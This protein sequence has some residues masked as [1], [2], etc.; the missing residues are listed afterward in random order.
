M[1]LL[2]NKDATLPFS[3]DELIRLAVIGPNANAPATMQVSS[4]CRSLFIF[5]DKF[6][7]HPFASLAGKLPR[8]SSVPHFA[9]RRLALVERVLG[10]CVC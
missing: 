3:S 9:A 2:K 4:T 10:S 8:H 1:T 5:K 7:A 6:P